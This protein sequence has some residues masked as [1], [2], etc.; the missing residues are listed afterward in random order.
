ME[1]MNSS[2]NTNLFVNLLSR[3]N[4]RSIV[5]WIHS[6]RYTL[7]WLCKWF[8]KFWMQWSV[9]Q[10]MR[11]RLKLIRGVF[12]CES[13]FKKDN[14]QRSDT[15][16]REKLKSQVIEIASCIDRHMP[17]V[18][19]YVPLRHKCARQIRKLW[20]LITN[21]VISYGFVIKRIKKC[22]R[23]LF[24]LLG[25]NTLH[26]RFNTKINNRISQL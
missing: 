25:D 8:W 23:E 18:S 9:H 5:Q 6:M 15:Q 14:N 4:S 21:A 11:I 17:I 16:L 1:S 13:I 3:P 7:R 10:Y 20:K 12:V 19:E 26:R 22:L 2:N 24:N